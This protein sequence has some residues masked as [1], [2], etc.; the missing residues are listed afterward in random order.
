MKDK[1][2]ILQV[3][4]RLLLPVLLLMSI[5]LFVR[6]HNRPGGG[7]IGGLVLVT[8]L[9]LQMIAYNLETAR[10]TLPV[11]PRALVAVGLLVALGSGLI[12]P[13][14][15]QPFMTGQWIS[16]SLGAWEEVHLGTPMLFDLG[17]Y[18]VVVGAISS[19]IFLLVEK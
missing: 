6:G 10:N 9:A 8:V 13:I 15:G 11:P 7:F 4:T 3:A 1:S 16:F 19:I 2:F 5:F 18:L 12:G 14:R 17:V